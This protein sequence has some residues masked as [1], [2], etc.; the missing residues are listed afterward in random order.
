MFQAALHRA[1]CAELQRTRSSVWSGEEQPLQ[2]SCALC[3]SSSSTTRM[4]V[5]CDELRIKVLFQMCDATTD[6]MN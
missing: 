4:Q 5:K 3:S 2:E 1:R 6:V